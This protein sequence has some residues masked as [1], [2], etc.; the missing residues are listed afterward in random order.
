MT[1]KLILFLLLN[2]ITVDAQEGQLIPSPLRKLPKWVRNEF[3]AKNL[4][5]Q[6]SLTFARHPAFL[7]GD[8]NGDGRKDIAI[9]IQDKN[10]GKS[11]IVIFHAKKP[12]I[13]STPVTILGAGK[14]LGRAGDNF[15]Q[16]DMWTLVPLRDVRTIDETALHSGD[17]IHLAKRDSLG[18]FIYW[19]G[20]QYA[21]KQ[22]RAKEAS[23]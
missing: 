1:K 15:Q 3:F 20:K 17:A 4:D 13:I 11:G 18:G 8:F 5:Q 10:T 7:K 2:I 16:M 12:Q 14:S 9:Q 6:Y 23:K 19:N 22:K 21:W